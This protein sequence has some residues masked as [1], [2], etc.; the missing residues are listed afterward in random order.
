MESTQV[1]KRE[2]L[3]DL[4]ANVES[5]ATPLSSML[6]KRKRP[7]NVV[8][9]WQVKA[10][11]RK[12]HRGVRDGEDAK[13]F[14][15][16]GRERVHAV[17]QKTWD[18]RGVSDFAEESDVAGIKSEKGEQTADAMVTLKQT[19]ERRLGSNEDCLLQDAANPLA[20]NETRGIFRWLDTAAQPLYPVPEAFRPS[21]AQRYTGTLANFS[22]D[23]LKGLAR[24]AW[25]R[26]LGNSSTLQGVVGIDLKAKISDFTRYDDTVANKTNV[27]TFNQDAESQAVINIIDRVVLDTGVINLLASAHLR[28]DATTGEETAGTHLS[29]LFIDMSMAGLAYTR[30]PRAYE[31]PYAGGGYKVVVDAIFMLMLDNPVGCFS[32]LIDS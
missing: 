6:A 24:A 3:A 12:G 27:R 22:E 17:S 30:M 13:N 21:S 20:N 29:G 15:H 4:I 16:N 32:A 19:I 25:K 9:D 31:L 14:D 5:D 10:Y 11:K 8:Q 1:G 26:R 2:A 23:T 7:G 28:T 18:P